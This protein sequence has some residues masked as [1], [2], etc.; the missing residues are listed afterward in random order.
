MNENSINLRNLKLRGTS[1]RCS[2]I[3]RTRQEIF[4]HLRLLKSPH[5][6]TPETIK[7]MLKALILWLTAALGLL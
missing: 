5:L 6:K 7:Q 2:N 4:L 1:F 3:F